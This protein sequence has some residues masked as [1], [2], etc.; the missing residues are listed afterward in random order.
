MHQFI[1]TCLM[2]A[3]H[4]LLVFLV[5]LGAMAQPEAGRT[6]LI[7]G[8]A[9]NF[10]YQEFN[11]NEKRLNQEEGVIPGLVVRLGQAYDHWLIVG[12]FS[13]YDGDVTYNGQTNIGTPVTTRTDQKIVD[14]AV[15]A[16]YWQVTASGFHYALYFGAGYYYRERDIQPTRTITG[17]P[18]SGL[19]ETYQWWFGFLGAKTPLYESGRVRWLLDA[20]FTRPVNPSITVDFNGLSDRVRLDLGERWG[21]RWALPWRYA[22]NQATSFV[23]EPFV[24][25]YE[26]GRSAIMPLTRN[27]VTI[28]AVNEP[29][30]ENFN[31]GLMVGVQQRF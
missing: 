3:L 15:H 20:R 11:S 14:V 18:V 12:D 21:V 28:G 1:R 17:V 27:G 13:Y 29:R 25:S 26:L 7:S 23:I 6:L 8:A 24:E 9:L 22:M 31:Y 30:S 10:D 5:P 19:F 2:R 16:E 4:T